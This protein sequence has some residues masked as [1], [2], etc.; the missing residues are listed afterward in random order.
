MAE[1]HGPGAGRDAAEVG[2]DDVRG[3]ANRPGQPRDHE[4]RAGAVA[5]SLPRA[6]DNAVVVVGHHD[7]VAC[8]QGE[9]GRDGVDA[10]GCVDHEGEVVNRTA[11]ESGQAAARGEHVFVGRAGG[12]LHGVALV[13]P[14]PIEPRRHDGPGRRAVSAVLQVGQ[15]VRKLPLVP[16][17]SPR[18]VR[19]SC[20]GIHGSASSRRGPR[21]V[22][23]GV[24]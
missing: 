5:G 2:V 1:D 20:E 24:P 13:A 7:L 21:R 16:P 9:A 10:H 19:I 23:V 11:D 14:D 3:R 22:R 8:A 6:P 12:E 15:A 4:P 17:V 18:P